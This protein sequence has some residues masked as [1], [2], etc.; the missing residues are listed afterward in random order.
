MVAFSFVWGS[1]AFWAPVGAHE[2]SSQATRI[3]A[4]LRMFPLDG[5]GK[6]LQLGLLS[7]LPVGFVAWYPSR[8]LLEIGPPGT[9]LHTPLAALALALVAATVFRRGLRHYEQTGSQRY[10]PWGHRS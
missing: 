9:L 4:Q 10:L 2:I 3:V 8:A 7:F 1:L 6:R 5:L